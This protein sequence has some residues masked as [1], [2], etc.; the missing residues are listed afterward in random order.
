MC[1]NES[2]RRSLVPLCCRND[3]RSKQLPHAAY[4]CYSTWAAVHERRLVDC[5]VG[6]T[7]TDKLT[8]PVRALFEQHAVAV[9]QYSTA[10]AGPTKK[11]NHYSRR[12]LNIVLAEYTASGLMYC[13]LSFCSAVRDSRVW[14]CGSMQHNGRPPPHRRTFLKCGVHN[15]LQT[16][17]PEVV[18]RMQFYF[19]AHDT[20]QLFTLKFTTRRTNVEQ[21]IL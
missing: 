14:L 15:M 17:N 8:M 18:K 2:W 21:V 13:E 19:A 20:W 3:D 9:A 1:G 11:D 6:G 10:L 12:S 16:R 7:R 5:C 4:A